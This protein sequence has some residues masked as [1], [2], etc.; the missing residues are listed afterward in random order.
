MQFFNF[1]SAAVEKKKQE[2]SELDNELNAYLESTKP[3]EET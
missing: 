2:N 3:K 1:F